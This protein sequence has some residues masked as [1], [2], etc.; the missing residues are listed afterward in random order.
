MNMRAGPGE[1]EFARQILEI[2]DGITNDADGNTTLPKDCIC[3]GDLVKEIFGDKITDQNIESMQNR[4]ILAP[5][6]LEVDE[7]NSKI[8][9]LIGGEEKVYLSIDD[10]S[11]DDKRKHRYVT[12]LL[13]SVNPNGFPKHELKLKKNAIIMLLRNLDIR[14]G[15]CNGTRMQIMDMKPNVLCCKI[16]TG[17]NAGK[18][19]LIPRITLECSKNLPV[20]FYRRQ[21][22]VRLAH[23]M[24]VN[25]SQGQ[26]FDSVGLALGRSVCFAHGQLYVA[27]SRVKNWASFRAKLDLKAKQKTANIVYK[28]VLAE[29]QD[30]D[31]Q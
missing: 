31:A 28:T 18:V 25:K 23:A 10:I 24:T 30:D 4:V 16:I 27:I 11:E 9:D 12:D 26:T 19:V 20:T 21:F 14:D 15:L 5:T 1:A 2:G 22:P 13:N 3:K 29:Q 6:N 7:I 8:L 17:D